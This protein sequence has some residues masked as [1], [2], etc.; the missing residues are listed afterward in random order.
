MALVIKAEYVGFILSQC[1]HSRWFSSG[2]FPQEKEKRKNKM[3]TLRRQRDFINKVAE[4]CFGKLL[5]LIF[6][7]SPGAKQVP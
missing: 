6:R 5:L 2:T 3:R 4:Y 7:F 1:F